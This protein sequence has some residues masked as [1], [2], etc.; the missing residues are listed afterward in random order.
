[1]IL[2][3]QLGVGTEAAYGT[4]VT[5]TR[6]FDTWTNPAAIEMSYGRVESAGMKAGQRT[7]RSDRFIPYPQGGS[8]DIEIEVLTKGF[9][10]WL[11]HMLG[12][13]ATVAGAAGE[14]STHT[15]TWGD[16][17][18]KSFTAQL[19]L[20]FNPSG[21]AQPMTYHGGKVTKWSLA[22]KAEG[23][24]V[25][26]LS[27]DFEDVDTATALAV[28]SYPTGANQLSWVKGEIKVA[29]VVVDVTEV[30]VSQD[31]G[32]NVDRRHHGRVLKGQPTDGRRKSEFSLTA[33]FD[34]L[35]Q[36]NRVASATAA[37]AVAEIVGTW[38]GPVMEGTSTF[39]LL[40]VTLPAAR[41]DKLKLSGG[42][43]PLTQQLTGVGLHPESTATSPVKIDYL[44]MDA[45]A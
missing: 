20:P 12:S 4:P 5:P 15:G 26:T 16:T 22:S 38:T 9:G 35:T 27:C 30:E 33:D 40:R 6:F 14:V 19:G 1:M 3:Y 36:R 2:D 8:G 13:V 45:V 44:T 32:L 7:E 31:N 42:P 37:G 28:A 24:L 41:L 17:F 10:F 25:A 29:G 39:P 23:L 43:D 34:S 18:G 11:A 21:T